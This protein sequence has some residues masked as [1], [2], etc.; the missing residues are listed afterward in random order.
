VLAI[1]TA[2]AIPFAQSP[3]PAPRRVP[4]PKAAPAEHAVPF[5][6]GETLTYD[7][8]WGS[9]LTAGSATITVREKRPSF[10]SV[11]WYIVAEGQ[12]APLLARLYTLYFKADTLLDAYTLA[13]QRGSIFSLEGRRRRLKI[14]RFDQR[15]HTATYEVQG[16]TPST[17][18]FRVPPR[19]QDVLSALFVVRTLP[20]KAGTRVLL[21]VSDS[22]DTFDLEVTVEGRERVDVGDRSVAAWRVRPVIRD[23]ARGRVGDQEL[24]L[25][26]GD[27]P[28]RLPLKLEAGLAVGSFVFTL[29]GPAG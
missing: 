2:L 13:S 9:F 28:R 3:R 22:G 17:T 15:T 5:H 27:D 1:V 20:M 7:V 19:A 23:I 14:T 16:G 24:M 12:P 25:W 21:P 4:P 8:A 18:T 26:I 6:P 10:D 29:R 11:A